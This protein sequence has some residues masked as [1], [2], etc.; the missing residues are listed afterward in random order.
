MNL[1]PNNLLAAAFLVAALAALSGCSNKSAT[2]P[3]ATATNT[4]T[5]QQQQIEN[6]PNLSPQAKAAAQAGYASFAN[7]AAY[8]K[9]AQ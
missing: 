2:T 9:P 7:R 8:A 5:Q 6:N 3:A 1:K 4:P